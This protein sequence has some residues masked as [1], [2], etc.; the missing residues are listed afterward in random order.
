MASREESLSS[1]G[2]TSSRPLLDEKDY[3]DGLDYVP[4]RK[5]TGLRIWPFVLHI[6]IFFSYT[7]AF[8]VLRKHYERDN[9]HKSLIYCKR[10]HICIPLTC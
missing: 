3:D 6:L 10:F 4:A 5:N 9:C 2:N 8:F 1:D 7:A